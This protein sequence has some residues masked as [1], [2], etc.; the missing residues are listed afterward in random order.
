MSRDLIA[1]SRRQIQEGSKSFSLASF[2]FTPRERAGAWLLYSWCRYCDDEID[3]AKDKA[4][5]LARLEQLEAGT[6]E[7]FKSDKPLFNPRFEGLRRVAQDFQIPLK[8]PLDLLRGMRMDV[9]GWVYETE[10]ELEDYCYC[11]AGVVGLMMCHIMGVSDPAALR[12]AIALG[13]AMQ[14]TNIARDVGDDHALGRIYFPRRWLRAFQLTEDRFAR[15]ENRRTWALMTR[16]LLQW[17][18]EHYTLGREGLHYLSFR[19]AL[20]CGIAASVYERIGAEVLRRGEGAWDVRC[21]VP[22]RTKILIAIK[23]TFRLSFMLSRRLW[24]GWKP[25]PIEKV[26]GDS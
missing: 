3:Q 6:R 10:E 25:R 11:V 19:A 14:L 22:L 4:E 20:A 23:E 1:F 2:F 18:A 12:H 8:Y 9:E 26:W 7:A 16:R 24:V 13:S 15:R 21:Y 5:A 17:A